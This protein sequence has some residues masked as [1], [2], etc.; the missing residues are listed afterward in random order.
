MS[1]KGR[2]WKSILEK[3]R[4]SR[5]HFTLIDP[6]KTS[7]DDAENI[8][9]IALSSGSDYILVGG[10][11]G[12]SPEGTD[13]VITAIKKY[14]VPVIIFPGALNNVSPRAD[15]AFFLN[16]IN[17]D[18]PY[19]HSI[20]QVQGA[21][22]VLHHNIEPIPTC[23]VIVGYGGTAGYM[24]RAR[25]IPYEK[26]ELVAAHSLACA[27]MGS[28]I[29]YLEAGS[30]APKSVPPEAIVYSRRLIEKASLDVLIIVGGGVRSPEAARIL[31]QA[32]A[33]GLVTGTIA[34]ENPELLADIIRAF[35][36]D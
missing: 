10:S 16:I 36:G 3:R 1:W 2:V 21:L 9:R 23:Y 27:M 8:A 31:A 18:D 34:E 30:G 19:Y 29:I 7:P 35:K 13:A 6:D 4:K 24:V 5:I 32:G 15:A 33:D 11:L 26:P 28:K 12:V 25:P 20:A 22:I 17:S 14:N